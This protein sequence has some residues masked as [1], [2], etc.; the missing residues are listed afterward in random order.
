MNRK[1]ERGRP[2]ETAPTWKPT[3]GRKA[4]NTLDDEAA[5]RTRAVGYIRVSSADQAE[6]G[7]SLPVQ[8]KRITEFVAGKDWDLVE[9][10]VDAAERGKREDRPALMRM[11]AAAERGAFDKAVPVRIDRFGRSLKH[12]LELFNQLDTLGVELLTLDHGSAMERPAGSTGT[13]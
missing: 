5:G 8:E 1:N 13:C 9:I 10:Y 11:M 3:L 12:N 4:M 6:H 7:S 2:E